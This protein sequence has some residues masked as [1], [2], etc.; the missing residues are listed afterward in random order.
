MTTLNVWI[1]DDCEELAGLFK[2]LFSS[3]KI[4]I[5]SFTNPQNFLNQ[6]ATTTP[7]IVFLDYHIPKTSG[8]ELAKQVP[9]HVPKYLLTGDFLEE[10]PVGINDVLY[11][12]YQFSTINQIFTINLKNKNL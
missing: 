10:V 11:K 2:D 6:I 4:K 7:D 12:P 1:V 8:V 9:P 5:T 3:D